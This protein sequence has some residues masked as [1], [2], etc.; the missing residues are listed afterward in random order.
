MAANTARKVAD[1]FDQGDRRY[2]RIQEQKRERRT[3]DVN[4]HRKE[5]TVVVTP[6][7]GALRNDSETPPSRSRARAKSSTRAMT[8]AK[9]HCDVNINIANEEAAPSTSRALSEKFGT[10]VSEERARTVFVW[11]RGAR[12]LFHQQLG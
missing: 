10:N 12:S 6:K 2:A 3:I 1:L 11:T 5:A 9:N 8:N 7:E 4:A